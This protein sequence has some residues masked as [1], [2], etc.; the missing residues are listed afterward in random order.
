[1]RGAPR[2][3]AAGR[4]AAALRLAL[5][6]AVAAFLALWGRRAA[7]AAGGGAA[8][9]PQRSGAELPAACAEAL[10]AAW[11]KVDG[12]AAL[13]EAKGVVP[14]FGRRAE[15]IVNSAVAAATARGGTAADAES[16]AQVI[17]GPLKALFVQQLQALAA[18]AGDVYDKAME[19]RPNPL[20][21]GLAAEDYFVRGARALARPGGSWS[22]EAEKADFLA[23]VDQNY[24][25][26]WTLVSEQAKSGQ[27]EQVTINNIRRLQ[28]QAAAVQREAE[29]RGAFP[30]NVKWQ[31]F[32]EKSPLGF[33]GHY[34]Q[35]RSVVELLLMPSP[36]P[37][38]KNNLL[39]RIGPL[40]LAVVFDMLM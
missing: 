21:A 20:E 9:P 1:M 19:E 31:Y 39:N 11:R 8:A 29:T 26:D 24:A 38:Q 10:A 4:G 5:A 7:A 37:R 14:D 16:L 13:V 22:A 30:W 35:G 18:R 25:R 12:L 28:E 17:D 2:P 23:R 6:A 34:Q 32:L 27:G 3:R 15:A 36:D 33:R 40:N